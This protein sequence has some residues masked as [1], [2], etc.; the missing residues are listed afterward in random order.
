MPKGFIIAA[1]G[2][3]SGKTTLALG[4]MAALN[5]RGRKVAPF[6]IGPDF[7]DPGHH[8]QAAGRI[9]RNL[10]GWMLSRAANER[11]FHDHL[12]SGHI[13]VVEGVMGLFDG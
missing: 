12:R 3:G 8:C 7:I 9:S 6:K 13:A 1:P 5:R 10:D 11:I 4:L 2:S